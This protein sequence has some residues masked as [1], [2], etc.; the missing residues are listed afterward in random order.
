MRISTERLVIRP[1]T[2]N[3]EQAMIAL[4]TN[5]LIKKTYM[6]P[7]LTSRQEEAGMFM[8]LL[9]WSQSGER[10]ELGIYLGDR[11]IGFLNEIK[12]HANVIELGYVI[13][14]EF[15]GKGYA[16]EA[17]RAVIV[18]LFALGYREIVAGAF[19]N[20]IASIRVMQKCGM[21]PTDQTDLIS[22]RC[23]KHRCVYFSIKSPN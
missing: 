8:K 19:E 5:D 23:K 18:Y 6:L 21:V 16:T 20:N 4:L 1:Y 13:H 10:L 14:P 9:E 11:F 15:H 3:D 7:D 12:D 17:L 2:E 22:Y